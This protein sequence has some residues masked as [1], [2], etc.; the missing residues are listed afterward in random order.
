M[1]FKDFIVPERIIPDL[2]A[3]TKAE[4]I[5]ELAQPLFDTGVIGP[6]LREGVLAALFHREEL[7]STAIGQNLSIAIPHAKHPGVRGLVGVF[8]RSRE[9]VEFASPDGKP[10]HLFFLLL[11]NRECADRHLEALAYIS[12]KSRNEEFRNL[13]LKAANKAQIADFLD[14]ADNE[15]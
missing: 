11:S 4:A 6:E 10:V 13:L 12:R 5:T 9:G 7:Q 8:G 2:A 3:G 15:E 14:E 1:Q